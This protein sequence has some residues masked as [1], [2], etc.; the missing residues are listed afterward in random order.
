M[1]Q[2]SRRRLRAVMFRPE[3]P[4]SAACSPASSNLCGYIRKCLM[5]MLIVD[6][7]VANGAVMKRMAMKVFGGEIDIETSAF[8]AVKA[9]H[10][11]RYDIIVT[12]YMMPEL[13]GLNFVSIVRGFEEY[14]DTPIIMASG[15]TDPT[16]FNR[17]VRHGLD[18][19]I[20]KP[21][22]AEQFRKKIEFF[23]SKRTSTFAG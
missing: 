11:K 21:L 4:P 16:H 8:T 1:M 20:T 13:N 22:D 9:C 17:I 5:R 15:S 14:K 6:D 23:L 3:I 19:F 7:D 12:D 2:I 10:E 18:C